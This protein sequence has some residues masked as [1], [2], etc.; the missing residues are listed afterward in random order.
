MG[1]RT[2][3][4]ESSATRHHGRGPTKQLTYSPITTSPSRSAG[5]YTSA[6]W[7]DLGEKKNRVEVDTEL[8]RSH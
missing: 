8:R 6:L 1:C 5:F 7:N 2:A 3:A 4:P